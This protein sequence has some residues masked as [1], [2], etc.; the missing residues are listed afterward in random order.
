VPEALLSL[1]KLCLLALLYLFFFRV[2]WAVW[3][4][5]RGPKAD[6]ALATTGGNTNNRG[7]SKKAPVAATRLVMTAPAEHKGTTFDLGR[8]LTVGRAAGCHVCVADD[9]FV[10]QLH[11][12]V[13]QQ[14]G[15]PMVEDLGST[16]GTY[17]NG[18]RLS[19]PSPMRRGDQLQVG[20][21]VME[22]S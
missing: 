16:N 9:T 11:A 20:S 14:D 12:R 10:S 5:V 18:R 19:A 4:E 15:Q 17:L 13:F 22:V 7:N 3:N 1:L 21:S 8:E 2:L 6:P